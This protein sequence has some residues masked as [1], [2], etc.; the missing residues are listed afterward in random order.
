MGGVL[1]A[2]GWGWLL[3]GLGAIVSGILR[4]KG[5]P[6]PLPGQLGVSLALPWSM[7]ISDF[8]MMGTAARLL[9][10]AGVAINASLILVIANIVDR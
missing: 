10:V 9:L 2:I 1:R 7:L 6:F 4:T 5:I 3:L 8:G